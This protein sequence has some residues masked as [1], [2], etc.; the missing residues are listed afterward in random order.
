MPKRGF[1]AYANDPNGYSVFRNVKDFGAKGD[2]SSDDTDAINA[3]ISTGGRCGQG[4]GETTKTPAIVYFPAGTYVIRRPIIPYYYTQLIGDAEN[5]PTL[6]ASADFSGMAVIDADPYGDWGVNWWV[7]QDNFWRGVRNFVIDLTSQPENTGTGIHWQVSQATYLQN[8]V[9]N[10]RQGGGSKQSGIFMENGSG[11]F[12]CDLTFNGG[13]PAATFGN[14]QFTMRNLVFN[15]CELGIQQI[16][17]WVWNYQ[18]CTFSNCRTGIDAS[19]DGVGSVIVLDSTFKNCDVGIK[20]YFGPNTSPA[21][22]GTLVIDNCDFT[23]T[24]VALQRNGATDLAG[25]AKIPLYVKGSSYNSRSPVSGGNAQGERLIGVPT[26]IPRKPDVLLANGKFASRSRPQYQNV[27]VSRFLSARA[28]GATGNGQ[29]DDTAALQA[30]FD[31]AGADDVVFIDHGA[32]IISMTIYIKP[33]TRIT[34]EIWPL[35][36]GKGSA[37]QDMNNPV[38]VI[39]VGREGES[40]VVEITDVDI[41]IQGPQPGA[42]LLQWNLKAPDNRKTESGIWDVHFRIGGCAGSGLQ[43]PACAK[44]GDTDAKIAQCTGCFLT[45][46]ITKQASCYVENCWSWLADHEMDASG[47]QVDLF[48]GRGILVES[49]GPVWLYGTGSE[50][51]TLYQY[52][53]SGAK[54][55][56]VGL[57]QTETPYYQAPPISV[58]PFAPNSAWDDPT[59]SK[60]TKDT[61]RKSWGIRI[62]DSTDV[63]WYG[64]GSYSFFDRYD[65]A[66]VDANNCQVNMVGVEGNNDRVFLFGV[67][68][69]ASD[70][71]ITFADETK[72]IPQGDNANTFCQTVGIFTDP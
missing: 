31:K 60:C 33:G 5:V 70:S 63:Y 11:G 69:K 45:F 67:S 35:L 58:V 19:V 14:Q 62:K 59:Y 12:I 20:S 32:Y 18:D 17:N 26:T 10:L 51:H 68:T 9:F 7:N 48:N 46:H 40:G 64:A 1:A 54:N 15:N 16:W 43:A 66:C 39:Q 6:K 50:H 4:C 47:G 49:Q 8:I 24:P 56:Y 34:G 13:N 22:A 65:Q 3:A 71:I 21:G 61:C 44:G 52:Q 38:P 23:G 55:V 57:S 30:L 25:N 27:P 28:N 2:G 36:I 41:T 42:I 53:L 29:A 37:F 72:S